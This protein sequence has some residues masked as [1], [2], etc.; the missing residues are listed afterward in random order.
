MCSFAKTTK[1]S[2]DGISSS[3]IV[4]IIFKIAQVL[5]RMNKCFCLVVKIQVYLLL[6]HWKRNYTLHTVIFVTIELQL[7]KVGT[8][9]FTI[10]VCMHEKLQS[11][12]ASTKL[13][14]RYWK[15]GFHSNYRATQSWTLLETFL[16]VH[17][18]VLKAFR[19]DVSS[20][21][22]SVHGRTKIHQ[23]VQP[24]RFRRDCP[25]FCF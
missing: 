18:N 10:F 25:L 17:L 23:T 8:S 14:S 9:R 13:C 19:A 5:S 20:G 15:I 16:V 3:S 21:K 4:L 6:K 2:H 22:V 7:A 24:S 12:R 1:V 11:A